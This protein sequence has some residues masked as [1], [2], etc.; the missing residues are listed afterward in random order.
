MMP[1]NNKEVFELTPE[2]AE[3]VRVEHPLYYKNLQRKIREGT[4]RVTTDA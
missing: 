2:E 3:W 1:D 4:A